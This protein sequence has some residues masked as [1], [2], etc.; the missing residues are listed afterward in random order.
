MKTAPTPRL[1][2]AQTGADCYDWVSAEDV[3]RHALAAFYMACRNCDTFQPEANPFDLLQKHGRREFAE[4]VGELFGLRLLHHG[5]DAGAPGFDHGA[6]LQLQKWMDP[7]PV[8]AGAVSVR[9]SVPVLGEAHD[10][11]RTH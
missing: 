3:L 1:W 7:D 9:P 5:F 4:T 11:H 6:G 2:P 10:I 8:P